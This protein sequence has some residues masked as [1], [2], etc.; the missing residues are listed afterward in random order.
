MK[1]R[2]S[3]ATDPNRRCE[4]PFRRHASAIVATDMQ[5][6]SARRHGSGSQLQAAKR[7]PAAAAACGCDF[8]ACD[9]PAAAIRRHATA[10]RGCTAARIRGGVGA[11]KEVY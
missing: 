9:F 10:F 2:E 11:V 3:A 6:P 8:A 5:P 7:F 4:D 1:N